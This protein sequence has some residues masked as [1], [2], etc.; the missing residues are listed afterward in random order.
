[1]RYKDVVD[2]FLGEKLNGMFLASMYG[3]TGLALW[4]LDLNEYQHKL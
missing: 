4:P 2:S 1:M 3:Y